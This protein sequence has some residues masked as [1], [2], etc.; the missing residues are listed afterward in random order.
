MN[1]TL[2]RGACAIVG[3]AESDIGQV[4]PGR[5]PMDLMGQATVRALADCGLSLKDIDGVF[6]VS[7]QARMATLSL[8]VYLGI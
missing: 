5:S 1:Q 3:V 4:M 6:S 8:S 2:K 7:S